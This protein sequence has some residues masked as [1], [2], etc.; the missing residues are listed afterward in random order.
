LN[1]GGYGGG[2]GYNVNAKLDDFRIYSRALTTAEITRLYNLGR[3]TVVKSQFLLDKVRNASAAYSVRK[4]RN[5]YAGY[6]M[7]VRRTSPAG[8]TNI[9]Y[10]NGGD[11]DTA[12]LL[13]YCASTDCFVSTW[14]DQSGNGKN[15]TQTTEANQPK[16]VSSG[17]L[18]T[19]SNG[20]AELQLD[21]TTDSMTATFTSA[22]PLTIFS[23]LKQIA[24]TNAETLFDNSTWANNATSMR[25]SQRG[26]SPQVAIDSD[27]GGSMNTSLTLST[28][29]LVTVR[30][31]S[32][33]RGLRANAN[34]ETTGTAPQQLTVSGV[35]IGDRADPGYKAQFNIQEWVFYPVDMSS[36]NQTTVRDDVNNYFRI[37]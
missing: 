32:T 16:I 30:S 23:T 10:L 4:L 20:K 31:S 34:S 35:I 26:S 1:I 29:Y 28:T 8:S 17:S 19:G 13:S 27:G 14:Y 6:A 24:W 25:L 33:A 22:V 15:L 36:A 9:G 3:P 2:T 12:S 7:T 11:L 21:G 18:I 37:Y 5:A